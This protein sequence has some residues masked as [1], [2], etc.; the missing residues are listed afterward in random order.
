MRTN[1]RP[2]AI[3]RRSCADSLLTASQSD[4]VFGSDTRRFSIRSRSGLSA[5]VSSVNPRA[6]G[7]FGSI[8]INRCDA[9]V[10]LATQPVSSNISLASFRRAIHSLGIALLMVRR[11]AAKLKPALFALADSQPEKSE[12]TSDDEGYP[13]YR[14][15][16]RPVADDE[17]P[18]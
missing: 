13:A 5:A 1:R 17:V 3:M 4:G 18:L 12:A 16:H 6:G 10:R 7:A 2:I 8:R 14:L 15:R 11:R 9:R